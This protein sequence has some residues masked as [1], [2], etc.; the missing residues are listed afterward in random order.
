[1]LTKEHIG[2]EQS[3]ITQY[4]FSSAISKIKNLRLF[5]K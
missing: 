5:L 1:M 2:P 4:F 3:M